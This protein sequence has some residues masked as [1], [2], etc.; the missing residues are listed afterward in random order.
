MNSDNTKILQD[1]EKRFKTLM[2]GSLSRFEQS[3]GYLWNHGHEPTDQKEEFFRDK[4]EDL[5]YDLLN[6][7][8][9]QIRLAISELSDSLDKDSKYAYKYN[10]IMKPK[11]TGNGE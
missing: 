8:N 7:G 4:W 1:I 6:H 10:F 5:R 11:S 3:F 9:N 2:I